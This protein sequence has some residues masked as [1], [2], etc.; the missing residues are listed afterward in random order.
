MPTPWLP[1]WR[2]ALLI[3]AWAILPG[4]N[5]ELSGG[6]EDADNEVT[7]Q[8]AAG[9][10]GVERWAVKTGTDPDVGKVNLVP[11]G[12]TIGALGALPVPTSFP[13]SG[14]IAPTELETILLT[15]VTLTQYK[16]E[17]DSDYHLVVVDG[18][19]S[20]IVEIPLPGCVGAG[21]PLGAGITAA[22]AAFDAK[23]TATPSFQTANVPVTVTGVAFLDVPHG[24]TGKAP[25]AIELHPVLSIC[26]GKDCSAGGPPPPAPPAAPPPAPPP[27][28]PDLG[29]GG[30]HIKTVFLIL[31]E[32]TNWS[33]VKGSSSAPYINGTLLPMAAHAEH[34]QNPPG[35]HPSEPNYL[36]LEA[37]TNFGITND[38]P[39]SSNHQSTTAH[40]VT[41][42]KKA[43]VTWRA[44]EEDVPG[45]NC[46]L[47]NVNK[48]APKHLPMVFFDD[49]TNT[50][51]A[52]SAEC[53]AHVRPYP[54]LATDLFGHTTAQYNFITPNLC[55]DMHNLTGCAKS[56][57]IRNG[58]N[59]LAT[60]VPK[61][62]ASAAYADHG[63]L[64]ITWDESEG[65][66][67][68]IGMIVLSPDGKGHG[69]SN[70][71]PYTH[72][73]T[74]RTLQ[75]IFGIT[76]LLGDA[77]HATDLADLFTSFP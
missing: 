62:L 30:A 71:I 34:Y 31:M 7:V 54:Q 58:D 37:G 29:T 21:G 61:I 36:W 20:M 25:N 76:P 1:P 23:L 56:D 75:E 13:A 4:C 68:P 57:H 50:N 66:D 3:A 44:Y 69:Y 8:T 24:Q 53:I 41:L 51:S 6:D 16:L 70:T 40:L 77:A 52:S 38:N 63:A 72:S 26:L 15:N 17:T 27:P 2:I 19:K 14:R 43:G 22:R 60:E 42:M 5:H 46:P 49:V 35:N 67:V 33:Q 64:F 39:P 65:G 73:S 18:S 55:N 45:T 9:R 48:F 12:N 32:N 11:V 10:C 28:V 47:T 59:W 74:L